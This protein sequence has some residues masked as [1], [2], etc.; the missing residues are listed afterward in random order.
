MRNGSENK[1]CRS[2]LFHV[3]A[4]QERVVSIIGEIAGVRTTLH[5]R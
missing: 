1:S 5:P 3:P 4:D 2:A